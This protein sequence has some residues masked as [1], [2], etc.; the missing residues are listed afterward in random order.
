MGGTPVAV[1][2]CVCLQNHSI[3]IIVKANKSKGFPE[4]FRKYFQLKNQG[5]GASPK[6]KMGVSAA[7]LNCSFFRCVRTPD[8]LAT[9]SNLISADTTRSRFRK[10]GGAYFFENFSFRYLRFDLKMSVVK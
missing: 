9:L 6:I 3:I 10:S 8:V 4:K 2:S 1:H 5:F 7:K